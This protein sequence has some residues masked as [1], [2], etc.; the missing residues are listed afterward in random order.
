MGEPTSIATVG[1]CEGTGPTDLF[2]FVWFRF[3]GEV[4]WAESRGQGPEGKWALDTG[5]EIHGES[6]KVKGIKE[7]NILPFTTIKATSCFVF[8]LQNSFV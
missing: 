2:D 5:C 7:R 4:A 8:F 1:A 3:V 6:L